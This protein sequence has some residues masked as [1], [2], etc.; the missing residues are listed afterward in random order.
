[1]KKRILIAPLNWGL[2]HSTRCIPVINALLKYGF[3]PILAS[4]GNNLT[5]LKKE[6]PNLKFIELPS[7]N[8]TYPKNGS[9]RWHLLKKLPT[10]LSAIKKEQK[11]ISCLI[12][13][14]KIDGIISDNRFGVFSKK[15]PSVYITHQLNVFSGSTSCI[16]SK[17]HRKII[18][19]FDECW[20][21]DTINRSL[22]GALSN[23]KNVVTKTKYIG[24][25]SRLKKQTLEIEYNLLILLSGPEPQRSTLESLLLAQINNF[26][27]NI[28]FVR[29]VIEDKQTIVNKGKVII[30]N[31]LNSIQ[32]NTLINKSSV[33]LSRSGYSTIMDLAKLGK[34]AFF[35]PT[36]GQYEQEYLAIYLKNKNIAPFA[37]Q[38]DFKIESLK[39]VENYTG[40]QI[41]ISEHLP[42]DLFSLFECK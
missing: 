12:D 13:S 17:I 18:N 38:K 5:F 30:Y 16:S 11:V 4:D 8:I 15:I 3:D 26:K 28:A 25:L 36:P 2:G 14:K 42:R 29:G 33:V 35:I 39:K 1:M 19:K 9:F 6:F 40:F 10:I 37:L 31:Y 32:L 20:V 7:Y 27:G 23:A 34:K 24:A 21:P 22:S 41:P